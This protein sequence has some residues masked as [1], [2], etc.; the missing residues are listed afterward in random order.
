MSGRSRIFVQMQDTLVKK[1]KEIMQVYRYEPHIRS[2]G[3]EKIA[4][5]HGFKARRWIV[6][7]VHSWFNRFRKLLVRYEKTNAAYESLLQLAASIIIFRKLG[8]I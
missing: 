4:I 3:E 6:E 7:V 5:Q 2:R 8:V 1:S